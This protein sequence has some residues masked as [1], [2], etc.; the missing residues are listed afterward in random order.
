MNHDI[1][2]SYDFSAALALGVKY[3]SGS[4]IEREGFTFMCRHCV[5]DL[6]GDYAMLNSND[7][8]ENLC[9]SCAQEIRAVVHEDMKAIREAVAQINS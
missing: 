4:A 7:R 6:T 9:I 8:Y 2:T 5:R 1:R 3:Y